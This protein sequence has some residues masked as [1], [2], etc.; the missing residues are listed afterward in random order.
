MVTRL[1]RVV[2]LLL[3]AAAATSWA[4][5]PMVATTE[6][7]TGVAGFFN[8]HK[9]QR[10]ALIRRPTGRLGPDTASATAGNAA[11]AQ[12]LHQWNRPP[13]DAPPPLHEDPPH[14]GSLPPADERCHSSHAEYGRE[15]VAQ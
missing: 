4:D 8:D 2:S 5:S 10:F 12:A 7:A 3:I 14:P 11:L 9:M 6:P 15:G 1:I 13:M